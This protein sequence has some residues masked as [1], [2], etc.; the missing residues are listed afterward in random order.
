MAVESTPERSFSLLFSSSRAA[1]ATTGCDAVRAEMRRRH[2]RPQRRLDRPHRI[3]EEIGDAGQ[4]LVWLGVEDVQDG[5]DQQ[6]NGSSSP[7]GSAAR[8]RLPD[9]PG[10]RRCSGRRALPLRRGEP[11]AAGCR[12]RSRRW[13]D[14]TAARARSG[15][16]IRPSAPVLALDV[17]DDRRARPGQQC[18]DDEADALAAAGRREAQHMLGSV[19]AQI[20]AAPPPEEHAVRAE[21]GRRAG[22]PSSRPS[23][24]S[25]RS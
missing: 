12:R 3:R 20:L 21:A 24:P 7:N 15:R 18:R 19:M 11:R 14:R 16:A 22:S 9:R 23:A 6:A 8:A 1:L 2:H 25:R 10:R 5:A 17:V 13:S 4:R